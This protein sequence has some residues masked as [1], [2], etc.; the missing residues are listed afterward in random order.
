[1]VVWNSRVVCV[2]ILFGCRVV[3]NI[4]LLSKC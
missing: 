3:C 1:M 2:V 4:I